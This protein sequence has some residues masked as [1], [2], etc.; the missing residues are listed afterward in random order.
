MSPQ[1]KNKEE[2]LSEVEDILNIDKFA[3]GMIRSLNKGDKKVAYNLNS[4]D[5]PTEVKQWIST[6]STLL[7]YAIANKRNG[8][9][10]V[11]KIVEISGLT[12]TGKSLLAF[13][14]AKNTQKMGGIVF[15][16]DTENAVTEIA[17]WFG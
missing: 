3:S 7:D 4:S 8:G 17:W 5:S 11:G 10:P 16:L 2:E 9:I 14:I 15:Y 6:G 13:H 1:R 12:G